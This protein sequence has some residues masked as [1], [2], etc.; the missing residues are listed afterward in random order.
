MKFASSGKITHGDVL[1]YNSHLQI[2]S[3]LTEITFEFLFHG[4]DLMPN[5]QSFPFLVYLYR[6]ALIDVSQPCFHWH[7]NINEEFET[8]NKALKNTNVKCPFQ[9]L[10]K[11]STEGTL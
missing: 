5:G 3:K 1:L 4:N 10:V 8:E 2:L 11:R 6:S 7:I 9:I